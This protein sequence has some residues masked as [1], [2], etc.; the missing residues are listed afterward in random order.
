VCVV[1]RDREVADETEHVAAAD[2]VTGD[3]RH[4]GLRQSPDLD[5]QV[6]HVQPAD[7]AGRPRVVAEVVVAADLLVPAGRERLRAL[8][9]QDD[10]AGVGIVPGGPDRLGPQGVAHLG[11]ADRQ[12]GVPLGHLAGDVLVL[13]SRFPGGQAQLSSRHEAVRLSG[14]RRLVALDMPGD[15]GFVTVLRRT[16]DVLPGTTST[17]GGP[18]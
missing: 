3:H 15:E 2:G 10:D 14:V 5:L 7:R 4:D 8:P 18:R 6:E 16:R 9:R 12:L 11:P 13:S 1:R 17:S